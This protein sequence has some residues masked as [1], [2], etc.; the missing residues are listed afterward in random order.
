MRHCSDKKVTDGVLC[1]SRSGNEAVTANKRKQEKDLCY[2][3][4]FALWLV[5]SRDTMGH[6]DGLEMH[7]GEPLHAT[8]LPVSNDQMSPVLISNGI[9]PKL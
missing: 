4:T 8:S 1:G 9:R 7:S 2:L 5:R 3:S 6:R